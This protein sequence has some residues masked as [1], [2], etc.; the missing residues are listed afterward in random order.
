[1]GAATEAGHAIAVAKTM[2]MLTRT[3]AAADVVEAEIAA[4]THRRNRRSATLARRQLLATMQRLATT[5]PLATPEVAVAV[6]AVKVRAVA[7]NAR[8]ARVRRARIRAA[9]IR[10]R[11]AKTRVAKVAT[12]PKTTAPT[13]VNAVDAAAVVVGVGA[14]NQKMS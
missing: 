11:A 9:G 2:P 14:V 3:K 10:D 1:M 4:A 5:E 13:K 8:K 6:R 7:L 12:Q